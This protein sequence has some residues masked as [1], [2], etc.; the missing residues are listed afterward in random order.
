MVCLDGAYGLRH[1][2]LGAMSFEGV[3]EYEDIFLNCGN[4]NTCKVYTKDATTQ[5]FVIRNKN[6]AYWLDSNILIK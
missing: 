1:L 3:T 2:D 5:E 6:T 4:S